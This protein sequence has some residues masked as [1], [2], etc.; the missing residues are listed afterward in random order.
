MGSGLGARNFLWNSRKT[1]RGAKQ[2]LKCTT[3]RAAPFAL[4]W[5]SRK[6]ERGAK[7]FP[8]GTVVRAAPFALL[9]P[10]SPAGAMLHYLGHTAAVIRSCLV[11][12]LF[13]GLAVLTRL[14]CSSARLPETI[15][16]AGAP[17]P[18]CGLQS[19]LETVCENWRSGPGVSQAHNF[20][21]RR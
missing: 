6:T 2:F 10:A 4:L 20:G 8:T 16:G 21:V 3:V 5:N 13:A 1:E 11:K 17:F 19:P 14:P 15:Q 12:F 18:G 7:Q 9:S